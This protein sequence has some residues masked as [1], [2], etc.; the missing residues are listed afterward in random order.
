MFKYEEHG[1]NRC[2]MEEHKYDFINVFFQQASRLAKI[3]SWEINAVNDKL[4]CTLYKMT[5][6]AP[7]A[8]SI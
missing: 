1:E 8:T 3:G 2:N 4:Y 7:A 5:L 6:S